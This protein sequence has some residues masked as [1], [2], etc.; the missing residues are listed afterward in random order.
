MNTYNAFRAVFTFFLQFFFK[1]ATIGLTKIR[2]KVL[3]TSTQGFFCESCIYSMVALQDSNRNY[4]STR[5]FS[6]IWAGP[7][8]YL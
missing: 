5:T 3:V 1:F 7:D 2:L 4:L 8:F 6:E